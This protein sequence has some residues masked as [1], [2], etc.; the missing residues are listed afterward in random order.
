MLNKVIYY[1]FIH[2]FTQSLTHPPYFITVL[3]IIVCSIRNITS[4]GH[5]SDSLEVFDGPQTNGEDGGDYEPQRD[6]GKYLII[7]GLK[8]VNCVAVETIGRA[9]TKQKSIYY[10]LLLQTAAYNPFHI[11]ALP[12]L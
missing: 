1:L 5:F 7:Q 4:D 8:Q 12:R 6:P 3:T 11:E 2:L 9:K 10:C